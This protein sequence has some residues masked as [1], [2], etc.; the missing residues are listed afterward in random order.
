MK[1]A[2]LLGLRT[3]KDD[4]FV[5]DSPRFPDSMTSYWEPGEVAEVLI[6][7]F[8]PAQGR[9]NR[10]AEGGAEGASAATIDVLLTFD[11]GGVSGH[12]NHIS[13]YHGARAWLEGLM[14]G[15]EGWRCPVQMYTLTTTNIVRKYVSVFDAPV[16]MIWCILRDAFRS[17]RKAEGRSSKGREGTTQS[18]PDKL[19]FVS[20]MAQ[21]RVAQKAMTWG[22]KSQ[23]R[24]F[25]WGWIGVGRYVVVNDL[26]REIS[27]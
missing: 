24:W 4:V 5:I 20:D 27:K 22:H 21:Y 18:A 15:R 9:K 11:K 6:S 13:L 26:K 17:E 8:E 10:P 19:L 14:K 2:G 3:P 1:S 25:R 7:A 12:A 16:S 23:M